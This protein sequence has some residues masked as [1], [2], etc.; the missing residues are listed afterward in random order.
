[1]VWSSKLKSKIW[2]WY[3][4]WLLWGSSRRRPKGK[5]HKFWYL[6]G[7]T[8]LKRLEMQTWEKILF[9]C[10][11]YFF[12]FISLQASELFSLGSIGL[13]PLKLFTPHNIDYECI[14]HIYVPSEAILKKIFWL[15]FEKLITDKWTR[16][17][18][19]SPNILMLQEIKYIS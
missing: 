16:P 15:H 14:I 1:M 10:F 11:C 17:F 13:I 5:N 8:L 7:Y 6:I 2:V 18:W 3:N 12:M 9:F 4:N 19:I